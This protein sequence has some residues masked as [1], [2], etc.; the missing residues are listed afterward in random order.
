M[1]KFYIKQLEKAPSRAAI[2]MIV[3]EIDVARRRVKQKYSFLKSLKKPDIPLSIKTDLN[4]LSKE[5]D[6]LNIVRA[7]ALLKIREIKAAE[8]ITNRIQTNNNVFAE[9]FMTV[10]AGVLSKKMFTTIKKM[11]LQKLDDKSLATK[12]TAQT[13]F[14]SPQP[15][16][17]QTLSLRG[18][19]QKLKK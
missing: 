14:Q 2:T 3:A 16:N 12:T 8:K 9:T 15:G 4:Y 1:I 7:Q 11:A 10:A 18:S 17:T 6:E 13:E 5:L 19:K